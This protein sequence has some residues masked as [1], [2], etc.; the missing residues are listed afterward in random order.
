MGKRQL[1][2]PASSYDTDFFEWTQ[3][4]AELIRSGRLDEVDLEHVAEE[5]EDMGKRDRREVRSRL[6]V[7]I[8]HLLKWQVQPNHRSRP[9]WRATIDE[10]RNQLRLVLDDSPSL[11]RFVETQLASI[12]PEAA[13][14][15]MNETG[16][17]EG[18]FPELCPYSAEEIL[19][20]DFLPE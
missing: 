9:S 10:Q 12:Y 7:L 8:M 20:R 19:R 13:R 2:S 14:K 18:A 6:R 5:I 16:L 15:A 17:A 4:T 1:A 3:E 11:V